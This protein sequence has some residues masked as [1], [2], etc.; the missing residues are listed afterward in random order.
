MRPRPCL[1][2]LP[3]SCHNEAMRNQ[4]VVE[5]VQRYERGESTSRIAK[6]FGVVAETVR[7]W[8][9]EAGVRRRTLS[10]RNR[11]YTYRHNAFERVDSV[12]AYWAGLMMADGCVDR[13]GL[14]SLE[15]KAEDR[16]LVVGLSEFMGYTGPVT[17]RT[18]RHRSGTMT[19]MISLRVTAPDV[20]DQLLRWGVCQRKTFNGIVPPLHGLDGHFY[21]G[22][23]DGD[24]CFHRRA[25][26]GRP[27]ASLCGNPAVVDSFRDWC[28]RTF[29]ETGSLTHRS[30]YHVVVFAG[31]RAT[32]LGH[33]LYG[34]EGP[35]L[36]RKEEVFRSCL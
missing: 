11:R 2:W 9:S 6:D 20:A 15:L 29:R 34:L 4:R 26:N 21:R 24:G 36:S 22:L 27:Q 16:E 18:R 30:K 10:E 33:A 5:I 14:I 3:H 31:E 12:T 23:F 7:R 19:E 17:S 35:R 28:W 8:L 32:R 25:D 13:R 1:T